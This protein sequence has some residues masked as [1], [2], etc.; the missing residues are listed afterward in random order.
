MALWSISHI[1]STHDGNVDELNLA[2]NV[3][4]MEP[5]CQFSNVAEHRSASGERVR[6]LAYN[7][8]SYV[9]FLLFRWLDLIAS[10][11]HCRKWHHFK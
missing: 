11:F 6:S 4:I 9:S 1:I 7:S 5:V 2:E 8:H 10:L 3:P